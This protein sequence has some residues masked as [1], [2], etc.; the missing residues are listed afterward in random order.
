MQN[1]TERFSTRVGNYV[2]YR[3]SYPPAI[4]DALKQRCKLTEDS[5][6]ADVGCG[7]GILAEM[8]LRNGN[9]VYGIEPNIE[10]RKA[11]E[12]LLARYPRF[13]STN[14]TAEAT[15]LHDGSV[16]FVTAGQAFHWFDKNGA[17]AEFSRIL[18]RGG[19]VALVWNVRL[20]DTTP[21]LRDYEALLQTYGT[22]YAETKH[23]NLLE[24]DLDS[25]FGDAGPQIVT[26][27]N[28]QVFDYE[29]LEGR[30]LSSSYTPEPGHP[31]HAPM[32]QALRTVFEAHQVDGIV[33]FE[34]ETKLYYGHVV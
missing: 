30:L 7:T 17:R 9:T 23:R 33:A 16:D 3:P 14:G 18:K 22:D 20:I 28:V 12:R 5:V 1:P 2:K 4:L 34:Y 29:G 25:F 6:I 15:T 11:S 21:F 24:E 27:P 32:L 10:M 31:N 19:W 26:F 8:F 13:R